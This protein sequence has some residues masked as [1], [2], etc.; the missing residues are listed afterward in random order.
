MQ[1]RL[2][3]YNIFYC[4]AEVQHNLPLPRRNTREYLIST[5]WK[6]AWF[7]TLHNARTIGEVNQIVTLNED[8]AHKCL[9]LKVHVLIDA[10]GI[11][12]ATCDLASR[13]LP[14]NADKGSPLPQPVRHNAALPFP[15]L[16][17]S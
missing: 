10:S 15:L 3:Q 5:S 1:V 12:S 14:D 6:L 11:S 16:G 8:S 13:V 7:R 4:F 2:G 9:A 17:S